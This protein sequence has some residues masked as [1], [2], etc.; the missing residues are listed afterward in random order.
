LRDRIQVGLVEADVEM[1]FTLVDMA[2]TESARG[3][4]AL[5]S[6]VLRDAE[7]VLHNI[8]QRL[9]RLAVGE[10]EPFAPLVQ[11]LRRQVDLAKLRNSPGDER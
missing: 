7:G 5:A 8:E 9:E 6:R 10:R 4:P 2:E 3:N 11:E 1:G